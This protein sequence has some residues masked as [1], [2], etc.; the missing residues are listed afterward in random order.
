VSNFGKA[1]R[2][3][4]SHISG[5]DQ[6]METGFD[7]RLKLSPRRISGLARQERLKQA[8]PIIS[9]AQGYVEERMR[10]SA[11]FE[12]IHQRVTHTERKEAQLQRWG[13]L[14]VE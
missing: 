3:N 13:R 2:R 11:S 10:G 12:N 1:D 8:P 7:M 4:E 6:Q 9:P 5:P 14:S